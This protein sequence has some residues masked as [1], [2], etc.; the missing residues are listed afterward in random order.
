MKNLITTIG[1]IR[2]KVPAV[3][4]D[5]ALWV[6]LAMLFGGMPLIYGAD[7]LTWFFI[8]SGLCFIGF[9]IG[10]VFGVIDQTEGFKRR[11]P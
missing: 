2:A 3:F 6:A 4:R 8:W 10:Y 1:G 5:G 7:P 11:G 9:L